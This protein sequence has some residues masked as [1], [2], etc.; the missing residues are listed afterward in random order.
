MQYL[1][2]H[3][4]AV[5]LP[6]FGAKCRLSCTGRPGALARFFRARPQLFTLTV[7]GNGSCSVGLVAGAEEVRLIL[8]LS[9][10]PDQRS[11]FA[12]IGAQCPLA[13]CSGRP[14]AYARFVRTRPHY[15]ELV[16]ANEVQLQAYSEAVA[17]PSAAESARAK[18]GL[19]GV[20]GCSLCAIPYFTSTQQRREHEGGAPHRRMRAAAALAAAEMGV[21]AR[22]DGAAALPPQSLSLLHGIELRVAT[23]TP[24]VSAQAVVTLEAAPGSKATLDLLLSNSGSLPLALAEALVHPAAPE[25]TIATPG[26]GTLLPPSTSA[27]LSLRFAPLQAGSARILV[28]LTLLP[29]HPPIA[30]LSIAPPYR[31]FWGIWHR[32]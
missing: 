20:A 9:A 29:Q 17:Q 19:G 12:A 23:A 21:G 16:G 28:S 8:F 10:R 2:A 25:L 1:S 32:H 11:T 26:E 3:P 13:S 5:P 31:A 14:G 24:G 18:L 15:F 27:T 4:A 6:E 7:S 22:A 30:R